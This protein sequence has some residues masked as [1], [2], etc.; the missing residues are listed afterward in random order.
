MVDRS[1]PW[2]F[3]LFLQ[4]RCALRLASLLQADVGIAHHVAALENGRIRRH[5]YNRAS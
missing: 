5:A 3:N 2:H 4:L 1:K